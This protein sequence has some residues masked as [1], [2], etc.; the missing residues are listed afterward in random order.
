MQ[1]YLTAEIRKREAEISAREEDLR[2]LTQRVAVLRA[3]IRIYQDVLAKMMESEQAP[4]R[5]EREDHGSSR[6][7]P[8]RRTHTRLH[9]RSKWRAVMRAAVERFPEGVK[10]EEVPDIQRAAGEEPADNTGVRSHVSTA[11][12][13]G[14][15][16]KL[17]PGVF[18]ATQKAAAGLGMTLGSASREESK[19]AEPE[20][21]EISGAP[22]RNGASASFF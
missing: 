16:E 6:R 9:Y 2:S 4:R 14:L 12:K 15:Y 8:Q 1:D 22:V 7:S 11:T 19:A 3:E 10:N 13:A 20:S 17:G 21:G 5:H 18:R